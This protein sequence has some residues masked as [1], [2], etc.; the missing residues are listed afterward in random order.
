MKKK[1]KYFGPTQ[2]QL[3]C[4]IGPQRMEAYSIKFDSLEFES[5]KIRY[6]LKD[7]LVNAIYYDSI[8]I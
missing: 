6:A 1:Y 3:S 7:T 2:L 4:P 8:F 5:D